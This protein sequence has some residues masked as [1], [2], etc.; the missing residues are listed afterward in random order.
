MHADWKVVGIDPA[1]RKGLSVFDEDGFRQVKVEKAPAY[2][3]SLFKTS[4]KILIC[5]DSPLTAPSK[6]SEIEKSVFTQRAIESFFSS[7]DW[8]TPK[9][10]SVRGYSGCPHW[11]ISRYL[12]GLPQV[13]R[14]D[15]NDIPF[16]LCCDGEMPKSGKCVVEVHPAVAIW[17]ALSRKDRSWEYKKDKDVLKDLL[18][19]MTNTE[20]FGPVLEECSKPPNN[21]DELDALVAYSLGRAWLSGEYSVGSLGDRKSGSFLLPIDKPLKEAWANF[22]RK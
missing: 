6:T 10:I 18:K 4:N 15:A 20:L 3:D 7:Q 11:T 9:G 19:D 14:Y 5:W 17:L 21:D 16:A 12:L 22:S 2:I 8:R 13:G 1:P